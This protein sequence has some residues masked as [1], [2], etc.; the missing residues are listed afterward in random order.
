MRRARRMTTLATAAAA[1]GIL[2]GGVMSVGTASAAGNS[3]ARHVVSPAPAWTSRAE[4]AVT[5]QAVQ[6]LHAKVWLAPRHAA[7]LTDL[8]RS[9][10]DPTSA[11]YGKYVTAAQYRARF[12]PE[13][14]QVAAVRSWLTKAGLTIET[15]GPDN[16]YLAVTGSAGAIAAAFGTNVQHFIVNGATEMAPT[17]AITVPSS[18]GSSVIAVTG[19]DTLGHYMRPGSSTGTRSTSAPDVPGAG[20]SAQRPARHSGPSDL[21][22]APGFVNARPCSS[23]YGQKTDWKDPRFEGKRLP[24]SVCGYKPKQLRNA[25]GVSASGLSG[26]GVTVAITDAFASPTLAKDANTYARRQGDRPFSRGQFSEHNAPITDPQRVE[27]CGGNAWYG[28]QSLDVEAV[29]G[30]APKANVAYYGAASCYDDDLMAALAQTV[31]DNQASMVTNSWGEPT[32]I[33]LD[34]GTVARVID[35]QLVAAYESI[36]LQGAVQGIGFYFSS[37][38]DG[39]EVAAYGVKQTDYPASDPYVTAVGGTALAVN[40]QGVRAFETGWGTVRYTLDP[41]HGWTSP[42]WLYGAGGG[43]SGWFTSLPWYQQGLLPADSGRGVPDVA[44]VADP[45]TG[46]LVGQT[47]VFPKWTRFGK[48]TK[49]GEYRVG[50]TSL[51]SPLMAGVNADAQQ[52]HRRI[53]FANPLIYSLAKQHVYFDVTPQGDRGNIRVDFSNGL[54]GSDGKASTVRTFDEDS[55]L[56]TNPGWDNVTGLGTPTLR[57]LRTLQRH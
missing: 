35:D 9:V 20:V 33:M 47:Q 51:A 23:Y 3:S 10:S 36:F 45:T 38:D 56:S 14:A 11:S 55:S 42:T 34:D 53:G 19:L 6:T 49:Y 46:M 31:T 43:Q 32:Y 13:A 27:D 57:Y 26:R 29:H 8:V 5:R 25:Y 28:E 41:K 54:N 4:H 40:R 15:V 52:G 48:G 12:A 2:L 24:Y 1:A 50:G 37:G 30:I 17:S 16:H 18:I 39:D 22:P 21:G 7:A 44:M